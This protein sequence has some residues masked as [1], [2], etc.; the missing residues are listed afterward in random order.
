MKKG[1][2]LLS[3]VV[4]AV[5]VS[6]CKIKTKDENLVLHTVSMFGEGDA[7]A[8]SYQ[9]LLTGFMNQYPEIYIEDNSEMSTEQWKKKVINSFEEEENTPDVIFYFT[10]ADAK[11][12]IL[13]NKV[14]SIEEIRQVYPD[15]GNTIRD[16]AMKFMKEFDGNSYCLPAKGFW[17]GLFCNRDIFEQYQIP[18]PY[19]WDSFLYAIQQFSKEGVIPIAVSLHEIPHYWIEHLILSEGGNIE[20][21]LNPKNYVPVSWVNGLSWF[22]KLY[23]LSAFPSNTF[24]IK[25][26]ESTQLFL[27]KKAAMILDGSWLV[28]SVTDDK[29]TIVLPFPVV[30][31]GKMAYG[32]MIAGYSSGYYITRK[33]WEDE[34]K[35]D[36]AVKFINYMTMPENIAVLCEKGGAPA[37]DIPTSSGTS[38]LQVLGN[39]LQQNAKNVCMPIDSKLY[40][41]AWQYLCSQIARIAKG[42]ISPEEVMEE[43]SK[44]NQW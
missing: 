15:Y 24:T 38:P 36:A 26:E 40:K 35:R 43:V 21:R 22:S 30:P 34:E 13:E 12:L 3:I 7:S 16:S 8:E 37:A 42:E 41:D 2:L 14:V 39:E 27:D 32:D 44:K 18:L 4:F 29:N 6:S 33:A 1:S 19:D 31:N 17:E 25:N 20:H 23:E 11:Q 28:Q 5:L 9:K 10:G